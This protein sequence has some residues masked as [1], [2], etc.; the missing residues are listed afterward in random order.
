L[1][2]LITNKTDQ[3]EKCV[4]AKDPHGYPNTGYEFPWIEV[5]MYAHNN[6]KGYDNP[7]YIDAYGKVIPINTS[8]ET[9]KKTVTLEGFK[10]NPIGK[11]EQ[12]YRIDFYSTKMNQKDMKPIE[13]MSQTISSTMRGKIEFVIPTLDLNNPDYAYKITYLGRYK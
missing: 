9:D 2:N 1:Q 12:W 10:S 7:K 6:V 8:S 4:T 13:G 3:S 11:I 5:D